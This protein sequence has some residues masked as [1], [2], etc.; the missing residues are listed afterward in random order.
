MT[1]IGLIP[2]SEK[3]RDY[4]KKARKNKLIFHPGVS[5]HRR[6]FTLSL[7]QTAGQHRATTTRYTQC[8]QPTSTPPMTDSSPHA[9]DTEQP[10]DAS[11]VLRAINGSLDEP[12]PTSLSEEVAALTSHLSHLRSCNTDRQNR[13]I[14][15]ARIGT[16]TIDGAENLIA[17]L[18]NL[19][20]PPTGRLR[21]LVRNSQD[22]LRALAEDTASITEHNPDPSLERQKVEQTLAVQRIR[23]L[24]QHAL[25]SALT[26]TPAGN[27]IWRLMHRSYLD[28]CQKAAR[29]T[30]SEA[31]Q[32]TGQN[33]YFTAI[34]LACAQPAAFT[35]RE[36]RFLGHY[37]A[38]HVDLLR[39]C[40]KLEDVSNASFWID[41]ARDAP[42]TPYARMDAPHGA[43][44]INFN[45]DRLA[46][47]IQK[48][49]AAIRSGVPPERIGLPGFA[50]TPAGRGALHRLAGA[51]EN[52]GKRR[53][54][55]RRQH[56]R[57]LLCA[58]LQNLWDLFS[59]GDVASVETSSWMIT[60]ESPDGYSIMHVLGSAS[61][62]SVG[63][64]VALKP[65]AAGNWQVCIIRWAQSE[66]QEHLEFGL[67]ILATDATPAMLV[68]PPR[69]GTG[70]GNSRQQP[71][72]ILPQVPP[73]RLDEMLIT[74]SGLLDEQPK[75]LV[76]VVEK[77]NIEVREV[78]NT[79]LNEQN[80]Q[81]EVFSI[82]PDGTPP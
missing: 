8:A 39:I 43:D 24:A 34:L 21:L 1:T 11:G 63:D 12:A 25:V 15:L 67:Q 18:T 82:E 65:E 13:S 74:R 23:A 52:P 49:L 60:N 45:C 2:N 20:P 77:G 71:V 70:Q 42:A 58:G 10:N 19:S 50:G 37:L 55:R 78:R 40:D 32:T 66:N 35:S 36:T 61:G 81:I 28:I 51:L 47:L 59:V 79:R 68:T 76:L 57:A 56:Y 46:S 14:A 62:T 54:P 75:Q 80:G 16:R 38:Q 30:P 73:L 29:A 4:N 64:V 9:I 27:G 5:L 48:Q 26:A 3:G 17:S 53:F 33:I 72:L 22:L 69:S 31:A 6:A 7:L 44:V 41:P